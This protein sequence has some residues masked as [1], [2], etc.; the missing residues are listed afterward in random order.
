M[1]KEGRNHAEVIVVL[2]SAGFSSGEVDEI[3]NHRSNLKNQ[4]G[5]GIKS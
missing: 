3:L 1:I 5:V 2:R 4:P